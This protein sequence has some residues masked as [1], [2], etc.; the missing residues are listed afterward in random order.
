MVGWDQV[1]WGLGGADFVG[2][3]GVC[4]RRGR[5]KGL[6][7]ERLGDLGRSGREGREGLLGVEAASDGEGGEG[8]WGKVKEISSWTGWMKSGCG[9]KKGSIAA[10]ADCGEEGVMYAF[11][12]GESLERE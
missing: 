3:G 8:G 2:G 12:V 5:G 11:M 9:S 6:R 1:C 4:S 7:E 10:Q